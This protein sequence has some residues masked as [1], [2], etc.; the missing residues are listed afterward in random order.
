MSRYFFSKIKKLIMVN[1]SWKQWIA[2]EPLFKL[3][4][5]MMKALGPV[6]VSGIYLCILLAYPMMKSSTI[7]QHGLAQGYQAELIPCW[8]NN[9]KVPG[10]VPVSL[11]AYSQVQAIK[12]ERVKC[13]SRYEHLISGFLPRVCMGFLRF[14]KEKTFTKQLMFFLI[15]QYI[16]FPAIPFGKEEPNN[17][18]NKFQT[19]EINFL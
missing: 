19:M 4:L 1:S 14:F 12:R 17:H 8:I 6:S 18:P 3:L 5:R 7:R 10:F 2:A 11:K 9:T 15:F 13:S 16:S